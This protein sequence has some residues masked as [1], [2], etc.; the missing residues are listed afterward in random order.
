MKEKISAAAVL[1]WVILPVWE[2]VRRMHVHAH[3]VWLVCLRHEDA[4]T[5]VL[6]F[7]GNTFPSAM[8]SGD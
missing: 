5:K 2:G 1:R 6:D 7:G 3:V 8:I 4:S